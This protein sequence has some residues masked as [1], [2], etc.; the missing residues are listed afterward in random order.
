[1][2]ANSATTTLAPG[3]KCL[4]G[5]DVRFREDA[6]VGCTADM[7]RIAA[8]DDPDDKSCHGAQTET[9][10]ATEKRSQV[11]VSGLTAQR[12]EAFYLT[13]APWWTEIAIGSH[14]VRIW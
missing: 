9:I 13:K 3:S 11:Q 10:S 5:T 2:T 4:I 7:G 6:I 14:A 8:I 1:M 12:R